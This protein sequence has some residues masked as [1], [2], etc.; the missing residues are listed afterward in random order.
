MTRGLPSI[1]LKK[2]RRK[3]EVRPLV[4]YREK[5]EAPTYKTFLCKKKYR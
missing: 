2:R 3:K 1:Q 4:S 5:Y